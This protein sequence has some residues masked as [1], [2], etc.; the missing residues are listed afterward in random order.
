MRMRHLRWYW[1]SWMATLALSFSLGC[2]TTVERPTLATA[3]VASESASVVPADITD[4]TPSCDNKRCGAADGCGG[5]CGGSCPRALT[6]QADDFG[7]RWCGP[8][9]CNCGG[10]VPHCLPCPESG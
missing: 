1:F 3:V 2:D 6:C 4:C 9:L 10:I 8:T 5:Q 7:N